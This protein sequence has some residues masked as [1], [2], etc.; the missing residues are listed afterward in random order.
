M[1]SSDKA[2]LALFRLHPSATDVQTANVLL[3]SI[4]DEKQFGDIC[5]SVFRLTT[6]SMSHHSYPR[7]DL[8]PHW[9]NANRLLTSCNFLSVII[10]TLFLIIPYFL[11]RCFSPGLSYITDREKT[12]R[13]YQKKTNIHIQ[14][15]LNETDKNQST[16][17]QL[18]SHSVLFLIFPR[19]RRIFVPITHH[20]SG[21][22]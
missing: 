15:S 17:S 3:K 4:T 22:F 2:A 12:E 9:S 11:K 20:K 14:P 21:F 19:F 1:D 8:S 5:N 16:S 18:T 13:N 6:H 10:K 7:A